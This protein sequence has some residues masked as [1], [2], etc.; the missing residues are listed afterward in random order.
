MNKMRKFIFMMIIT[1]MVIMTVGCKEES[2]RTDEDPNDGFVT[3]NESWNDGWGSTITEQVITE[4]IITEKTVVEWG[5][6]CQ[7]WD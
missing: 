2:R 1:S 6:N 3:I 5:D 4:N 7:T